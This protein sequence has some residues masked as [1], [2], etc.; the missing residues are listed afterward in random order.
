[1]D[2][3]KNW[4]AAGGGLAIIVT[5]IGMFLGYMRNPPFIRASKVT[6]MRQRI[7]D[8]ESQ[9]VG[10]RREIDDLRR[11]HEVCRAQLSTALDEN[12]RLMRLLL[13]KRD[14]N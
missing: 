10:F 4:L 14:D 1:M 11:E 7:T 8:L 2:E 12:L 6:E 5:V 9:A 3:I 13:K